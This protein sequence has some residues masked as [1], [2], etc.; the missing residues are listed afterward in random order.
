METKQERQED[1][2]TKKHEKYL[3][4]TSAKNIVSMTT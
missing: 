4:V 3:R 2:T 1:G